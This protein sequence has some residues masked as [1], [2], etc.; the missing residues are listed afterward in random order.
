MKVSTWF[1]SGIYGVRLGASNRD[2]YFDPAWSEIQVEMDGQFHDFILTKGF[3]NRCPEFRD[4]GEPVIKS[5]LQKHKS[6]RWPKQQPPKMTLVP[7]GGRKFR[8]VP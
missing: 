8:L 3:W 5:W 4:R 1:G 2:K 7:L 6:L